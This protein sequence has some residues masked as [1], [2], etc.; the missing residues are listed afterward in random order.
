[1]DVTTSIQTPILPSL[2]T[3][4][5]AVELRS[6]EAPQVWFLTDGL[7]HIG[8][9]LSRT[10]L[11]RGDYVVSTILREEFK[12]PRG[13]GLRDLMHDVNTDG[14]ELGDLD[15]MDQ[16]EDTSPIQKNVPGWKDRFKVLPMDAR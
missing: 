15:D 2:T 6:S 11:K 13:D 7:S 5:R 4:I 16:D 12:G 3:N 14:E 1:M 10:L 8:V 9:A